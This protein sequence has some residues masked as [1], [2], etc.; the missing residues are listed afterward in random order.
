MDSL[1][2]GILQARILESVAMPSS[3]GSSRPRNRALV[4]RIASRFLKSEPPGKPNNTEV[5]SLSLRRGRWHPTPVLLPGEPHGRRSLVGCSPWCREE[6][7][8]TDGL[9]F[10]FSLS[11]IG[12]G[13]GNPLQCSCLESPRDGG[14]LVGFHL[15]G[16]TESDTTG[17]T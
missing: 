9:R 13:H 10:H 3:R 12:V 11:C 5:G 6:S 16:R 15:W 8:T 2:M 1:S 4:S 7:G 17:A 14:S